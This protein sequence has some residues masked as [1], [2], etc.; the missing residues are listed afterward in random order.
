MYAIR[1]YYA[2]QVSINPSRCIP[3]EIIIGIINITADVKIL[4][5]SNDCEKLYQ[6]YS[7]KPIVSPIKV[8]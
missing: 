8:V 1:S 7:S 6:I 2:S 3:P 4:F 5:N